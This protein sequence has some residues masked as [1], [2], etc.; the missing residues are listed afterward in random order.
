M[1]RNSMPDNW[2]PPAPA[3]ESRWN[4]TSEPLLTGFFGIQADDSSL[5]DGWASTAFAGP[6]GPASVERGS[7]IDKSGVKNFIYIA[8]WRF[9]DYQAWWNQAA[10]SGWWQDDQREKDNAGFWREV[11]SMPFD[12]FETLHSTQEAHGIGVSADGLTGPIAEHAYPGGMRDRI[13]LSDSEDLRSKNGFDTKLESQVNESGQRV[14]VVP[15]EN[16]CVIRSGQNWTYCEPDEKDY[17]QTKMHAV[18]LKGMAYLRDNPE[19]SGVYSL[20]FVDNK[21]AQWGDMT[22]TFG[23]G[24]S[25]DIYAFEEWAKSHPTH[26]AIFET[27][28]T[29]VDT[30]GEN[31]KLR[32]WH[33]V[34]SIPGEGC[35]F[36]Y[37]SCNKHT[38]LLSYI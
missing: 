5:L 22:Q 16:M 13:K 20:R 14:L 34:T 17:Y 12:R 32:L 11:I 30:F 27:F 26:L 9:A 15:P 3:W 37:I 2:E 23:L 28:F 4:D 1:P 31:M 24:Y 8:Y 38:G 35:E 21:D 18:L 29:M 6:N 7:F 25:T 36:E 33:E 19:E 10:V